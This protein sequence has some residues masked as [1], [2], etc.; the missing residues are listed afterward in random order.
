[1]KFFD[2]YVIPLTKKL[3]DCNVFGVLSEE[4]LMNAQRNRIEWEDRGKAMVA[5]YVQ[6]FAMKESLL[7]KK[8]SKKFRWEETKEE[9]P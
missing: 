3:K 5:E 7:N 1:M 4:C 2:N 6:D 9:E 8:E